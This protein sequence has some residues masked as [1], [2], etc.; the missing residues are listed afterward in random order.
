MTK[1]L[2]KLSHEG[3]VVIE[4]VKLNDDCVI[5]V[6]CLLEFHFACYGLFLIVGKFLMIASNLVSMCVQGRGSLHPC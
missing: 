4:R 6:Q 3:E 1:G 2:F 5:M